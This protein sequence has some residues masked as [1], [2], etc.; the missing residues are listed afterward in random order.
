M[1]VCGQLQHERMSLPFPEIRTGAFSYADHRRILRFRAPH[2][3]GSDPAF[4][5]LQLSAVILHKVT[6]F[7]QV[8]C[9]VHTCFMN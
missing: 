9:P 7:A 8:F 1:G 5:L 2:P 4:K 3:K 6:K